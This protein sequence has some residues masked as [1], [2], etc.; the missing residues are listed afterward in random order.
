MNSSFSS[1][2]KENSYA[3]KIEKELWEK[4]Q[5]YLA[6]ICAKLHYPDINCRIMRLDETVSPKEQ[7]AAIKKDKEIL[8]L[9]LQFSKDGNAN[10]RKGANRSWTEYFKQLI[11]GGVEEDLFLLLLRKNGFKANRNGR[12]KNRIIN[13]GAPINQNPDIVVGLGE[14]SRKIELTNEYNNFLCEDGF[15]E[16]RCPA[17]INMWNDGVI[18]L[19]RDRKN[20]KYVLIDFAN[21]KVKAH[22]RHHNTGSQAWSKDVHRYILSENDKVVRDDT[23]LISEL[24]SIITAGVRKDGRPPLEEVEDTD[25]PPCE[26]SIGGKKKGAK[27]KPPQKKVV[28][29]KVE[30]K[31][32]D[33]PAPPAVEKKEKPIERDIEKQ[34]VQQSPIIKKEVIIEETPE[35]PQEEINQIEAL[36][37]GESD[38][39]GDWDSYQVDDGGF[40]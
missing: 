4:K 10:A 35:P 20:K 14:N 21:E 2:H 17:I 26:F 24:T 36:D 23:N 11:V 40:V 19:Y 31:A 30:I 15:I 29:P 38:I 1:C 6:D 28:P 16:K 5:I 27:V 34:K 22:L 37:D 12:D 39:D 3:W 9:Y 13:L 33:V 7:Q 32:V 25:S 18:W 8:A